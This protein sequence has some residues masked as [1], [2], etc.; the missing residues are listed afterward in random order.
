MLPQQLEIGR[1]YYRVTYAD[2]HMTI[3][4]VEP[5]IYVGVDIFDSHELPSPVYTFQDT[6]SY[7]RFGSF[8]DYRGPATLAD[9]G[10]LAY[11]FSEEKLLD[12]A[13]LDGVVQALQKSLERARSVERR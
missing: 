3:P 13:D 11:S 4:G 10:L 12:L 7:F 6:V 9:E 1:A 5:M 2:R 8:L